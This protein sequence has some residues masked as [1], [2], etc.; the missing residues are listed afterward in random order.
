MYCRKCGKQI[1]DH[2]VVCGYCGTPTDPANPYNYG[3]QQQGGQTSGEMGIASLVLGIV[4]ILVA[5]CAGGKILTVILA[6]VGIVLGIIALQKHGPANNRSM[7][8]AGI[9]CSVIA[10][11]L[12]I[13][14]ILL[15][16]AGIGSLIFSQF[17][18]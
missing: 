14:L 2:A 8:V 9:I 3:N 4:S 18:F 6:V 7:A 10:L 12:K 13:V 17:H 11:A 15:L 16:G 5:C 1:P